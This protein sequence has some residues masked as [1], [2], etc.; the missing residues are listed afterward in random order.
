M[1]LFSLL[2]EVVSLACK[3][4]SYCFILTA[5]LWHPFG[6]SYKKQD[7]SALAWLL[8]ACNSTGWV[9]LQVLWHCCLGSV[10]L[11][12]VFE[13]KGEMYCQSRVDEMQ[14]Q[15]DPCTQA[16][17]L[18]ILAVLKQ[19]HMRIVAELTISA[20]L[21]TMVRPAGLLQESIRIPSGL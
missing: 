9:T 1:S 20:R 17:E 8:I 3:Y 15:Q 19:N 2:R 21:W 6:C 5:S 10:L 12:T 16:L 18:L 11:S 4:W 7:H 14:E 13:Q